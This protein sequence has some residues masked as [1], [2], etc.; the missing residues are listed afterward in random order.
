M[1]YDIDLNKKLGEGMHTSVYMCTLKNK[2][3]SKDSMEVKDLSSGSDPDQARVAS[4][5]KQLSQ[6]MKYFA[7]KIVR[8]NDTE[9]LAAH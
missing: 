3:T 7:V 2:H 4:Q 6:N 9:K 1:K 5:L 8:D